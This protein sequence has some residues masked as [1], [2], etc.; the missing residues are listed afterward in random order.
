MKSFLLKNKKPIIKWG[1]L[2]DNV[3]F[4]GEVPKG[5]NL[6][7]SPSDNYVVLDIDTHG[8]INGFENIPTIIQMELNKTLN[9]DTK[10]NGKHYWMR[11]TGDLP[12]GNKTSGLGFDLRTNKGYVVWYPKYDIR[13]SLDL[14]NS[15]SKKMNKFLEK[16]FSFKESNNK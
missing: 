8:D 4:Q 7:V 9:Y 11:Y 12:L 6:A 1:L 10:N 14:I 15:T 3:F 13:D 5:Y 16:H 2:P